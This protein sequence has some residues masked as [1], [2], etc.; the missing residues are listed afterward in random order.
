MT[1]ERHI[2]I[3][4]GAGYI[5]S[6]LTSE[7]LRANYRVTVL[8]DL[9]FGGES[10]LGFLHHPNFHFVKTDVTDPRAVRDNV[11]GEWPVPYAIVHLAAIVGFP[12]CQAVGHQVA[13]R[14]NVEAT[15]MVFEQAADL[16]VG[17]CVFASTYSNYGLS[18]DGKPV[19]EDSLLNPQSLYAE[20][21]IAAEEFLLS[22]RDAPTAPLSFRFA[23]LYGISPRTRFDL[24]VNQFVL[25]A[26]TKRELIIYQRGYSRSFVHVRDAVR[27][28]IM[29][30]EAPEEKVRG[31]VFNLGTP[32]GNYTKDEIV[33]LV[34]K[35]IPE[36]IVE[37]K[38][39]TFGGDM[40]DI[41]VSFEKIRRVLGFDTTLSVDDGVREVLHVLKSGLI[42][43]PLDEK[44]RN[45]QFI[46]Q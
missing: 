28:I 2:L 20:T 45:A 5:G 37:Y 8:D 26:F 31:Q 44:Y 4:G 27:G 16:G 46:V 23:T 3:T 12:A 1:D 42:R 10:L 36:T 11:R 40:R 38:D 35:R 9:L 14:Y 6:L 24:I 18:P 43:D 33:A 30:L 41:T 32:E 22:Q 15:Q 19:T 29:G 39:L 7:L 25:E 34:L 13:W 21:K 17:R